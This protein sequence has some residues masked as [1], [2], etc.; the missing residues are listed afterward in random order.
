[1]PGKEVRNWKKYEALRAKGFSKESSARMA[2][3]KPGTSPKRKK[4]VK[5]RG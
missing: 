2:N 4:K 1:M 5:R 3:S